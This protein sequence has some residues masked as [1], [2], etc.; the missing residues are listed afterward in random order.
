MKFS[1]FSRYALT[2]CIAAA[3]L[4]GCGGSQPPIGAPGATSQTS[5]LATHAE[6]GKSWMLPDGTGLVKGDLLVND[7]VDENVVVLKNNA[8]SK[9][10]TITNGIDYPISS[11]VDKDRNFYATDAGDGDITEY[12]NAGSLIFT[13]TGLQYPYGVTTDEKGNVYVVDWL[14]HAVNEYR[15]RKNV[16]AA[17]CSIGGD[18]R[19][20]AV[21]RKGDVFVAYS[22]QSGGGGGITELRPGL[23][24][25][26]GT[27]LGAS[28]NTP[29]GMALDRNNDIVV[30]DE[31]DSTVAVIDPPYSKIT[32]YLGK[33]YSLPTDVTINK[34]NTRAYVTDY[35]AEQVLVLSYPSG[36][37]VAALGYSDGVDYPMSAVD[38]SNYVP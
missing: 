13:Y 10:G 34:A 26:S 11:W 37:T 5:A 33:G 7:T 15:Q 12:D 35:G 20:V 1:D 8:W 6:R 14:A 17:T 22:S 24:S 38:G 9:I 28:L 23:A 16:V 27:I 4:G 2:S 25:C 29:Y 18:P 3:L 36:S 19:G 32:G 30:C 31:G 21:D